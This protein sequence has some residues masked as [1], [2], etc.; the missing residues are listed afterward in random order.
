MATGRTWSQP[1]PLSEPV[2]HTVARCASKISARVNRYDVIDDEHRADADADQ[3][4]PIR[5]DA[6]LVGEQ[7]DR[8]RRDQSAPTSAPTRP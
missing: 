8:D 4:E 3:D 6:A 2:S 1:R 7:V 5:R